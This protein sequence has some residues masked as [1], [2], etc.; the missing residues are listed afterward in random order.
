ML[1]QSD[2][3]ILLDTLYAMTDFA[4][5]FWKTLKAVA[6]SDLQVAACGVA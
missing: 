5:N 3:S 2:G 4:S 1:T 6:I